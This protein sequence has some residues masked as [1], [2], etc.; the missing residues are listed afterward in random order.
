MAVREMS[1]PVAVAVPNIERLK[2]ALAAGIITFLLTSL[3]VGIETVSS[4]GELTFNT[5]F[6]EVFIASIAVF[7][8]SW[9]VSLMR[10]GR[11]LPALFG[12]GGVTLVLA[13]LLI[14][15]NVDPALTAWLPFKA[16]IVNWGV[17]IVPASVCVRAAQ[18]A[19]AQRARGE[20]R[21]AS[22]DG[23]GKALEPALPW[24]GIILLVGAIALPWL[25]LGE[26]TQVKKIIDI[27][28]IVLTYIMLGWGLNIVV[29]LAGLLDL[30]Y[31]AFYAVGAYTYAMLSVYFGWSFWICLPLAGVLAATFGVLLGFP[32]LRLRGDYLAIVTLGF[33]EMIRIIITNWRVV[34]GGPNGINNIPRASFFGLPMERDVP[35]GVVSFHQ[36]FGLEYNPNH[37]VIF[38]YYLILMCALVVNFVTMRLRKL[39]LGRAWEALREDETACRA[40]GI[41]PTN[42]KLTAFAMGAMFAGFA[43]SFFAVRNQFISPESFVF[44]ESAVILAIVVLGGLGSQIGIVLATVVLIGLPELF[45][46]LKDYRMLAFGIG[47]VLI[48][49]WRPGGLMAH[50]EPTIRLHGKSGAPPPVQAATKPVVGSASAG[51][52]K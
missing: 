48:M 44:L 15:H 11:P 49:I 38:L 37:R 45:R 14:W 27:C 5:R 1:R 32:V 36:F 47:M 7:F 4:T 30:G 43:G 39:P 41:N 52:A 21:A 2:Q 16:P 35:E 42:T 18:L 34:T 50:R 22:L 12:G 20:G 17:L 51:V 23:I 28:T 10:E 31:V 40:L 19:A 13:V 9:V 24:I 25:P 29:G 46:E 6:K 3:I 8:G 33:G 26:R